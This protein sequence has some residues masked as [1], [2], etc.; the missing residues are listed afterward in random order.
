MIRTWSG[1][2][3]INSG[4]IRARG[5]DGYYYGGDG[6]Y[7][8]LWSTVNFTKN[9]STISVTGGDPDGDNGIILIDGADATP[10]DGTIGD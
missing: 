5:G 8:Y 9:K 4:P 1:D 3:I 6:G 2:R 7:T 10:A